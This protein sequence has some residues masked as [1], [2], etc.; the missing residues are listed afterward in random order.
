[1]S[2]ILCFISAKGGSGKTTTASALGTFISLLGKRV[3]L[4]DTDAATNG[5]T[6][7]YLEQ[8]LGAKKIA[9]SSPVG[10]FDTHGTDL[11]EEI[12]ITD[13]LAFAPATFIMSDT[14]TSD[15][16]DFSYSLDLLLERSGNYDFIIMDAQAGSDVFARTAASRAGEL[17]VVSEYDPLSAQGTERLKSILGSIMDPARSWTLFNK[18]LP[19]FASF[20]GD[21]LSIARYLPPIP[22]DADVVRALARRDIALNTIDPNS[23][24]L[25]IATIASIIYSDELGADIENWRNGLIEN[26]VSPLSDTIEDY[27][28][29]I[30][31]LR[32]EKQK[33]KAKN[34]LI[35][36][37]AAVS[38]TLI[39]VI[40]A[41]AT[42]VTDGRNGM[43]GLSFSENGLP[44]AILF[45]LIGGISMAALAAF[46]LARERPRVDAHDYELNLLAEER[47]KLRT[48]RDASMSA[49]ENIGKTGFYS[50]KRRQR[51]GMQ[52]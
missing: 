7:L 32:Y 9:G 45:G 27:N 34:V 26:N 47:D 35:S 6:L 8:L 46:A 12:Q 24:T 25:A 1:M 40:A 50:D 44:W 14:D 43:F 10:L 48:A 41:L 19:E 33:K 31:M 18:V 52:H 30:D 20:I 29:R 5:M 39:G 51:R 3:L 38:A 11:A 22:W 4:V 13:N 16:E 21:G 17:V 36:N 23:Y 49:L 37:V 28:F 42:F 2:N 15:P